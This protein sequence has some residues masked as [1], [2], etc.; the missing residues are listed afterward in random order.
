MVVL[1]PV[2]AGEAD[3]EALRRAPVL[4]RMLTAREV[5]SRYGPMVRPN[6]VLLA[7]SVLFFLLAAAADT[8]AVWMFST[9]VDD[10]AARASL[11]RFW[12]PASVW[13]GLAVVGGAATFTGTYLSRYSAENFVLRLRD[14]TFACLQ[15]LS[16]DFFG[17]HHKGDLIARLSA[18]VEVVEE[19]VSSGMVQAA[20]A[21]TTAVCFITAAFVI[22]WDLALAV[23]ALLPLL[24]AA[25]RRVARRLKGLSRLAQAAEGALTA[26]VEQGVA[27]VAVI[28]AYGTE[29]TESARLHAQGVQWRRIRL[30]QSLLGAVFTPL[31]DLL[32]TAAVLLVLGLGVW[33]ISHGRL[34]IGGL[35]G[36]ATYLGFLYGPLRTLSGLAVTLSTASASSD[37]LAEILDTDPTVTDRP[38]ARDTPV[39]DGTVDV[40]G[41]TFTYPGATRPALRDVS[42]TARPGELVVVTGLSGAGKSTL[43]H[44]LVRFYDPDQGSIRLNQVDVRDITRGAARRGVTLLPQQAVI[45]DG[46]VADNIAYG[47]PA[48][49]QEMIAAAAGAAGAAEF[50]TRL[51]DGYTTWLGSGGPRLSGGQRQRITFARA[52]L[53]NTPILVIDEP[54]TGLDAPARAQILPALRAVSHGRTTI[55]IT[56]DLDVAPH[57]DCVLVF[58]DGRLV[59]Q[60]T[61]RQLLAAGGVYPHLLHPG[62]GALTV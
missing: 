9:I 19:L 36:F 28:Q 62:S 58:D 57:A 25:T 33:E 22:R 31:T 14:D 1:A 40:T 20:A 35:I 24:V 5:L 39:T 16:P 23:T 7:C 37:R 29:R 32:E 59:E 34:T 44:L 53:R 47:C 42:F 17:R 3:S 27:N 38:G 21:V 52:L 6:R 11:S 56:H 2:D 4:A 41:L 10:A 43:A 51:P 54:T 61:H 26:V 8:L 50:I 12:T 49:D 48:A 15:R 45:V 46:T 13:V 18:D 60:G 30:R 55:L